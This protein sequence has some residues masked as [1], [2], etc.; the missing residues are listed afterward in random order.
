MRGAVNDI[1]KVEKLNNLAINVFSND[2]NSIIPVHISK[3]STSV[4]EN[5]IIDLF[6]IKNEDRM[7]YCLVKNINYLIGNESSNHSGLNSVCRYCFNSF[8]SK[9]KYDNHL[10]VCSKNKPVVYKKPFLDY[11]KFDQSFDSSVKSWT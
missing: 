5:R 2:T 7:H 1:P 3:K 4:S 10:E 6:L 9:T 11:V 8:R